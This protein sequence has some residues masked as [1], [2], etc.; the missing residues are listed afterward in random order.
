MQSSNNMRM[1]ELDATDRK[2]LRLLQA[3]GRISNADLAEAIHLSP[4]S[5]LRRVRR[6]ESSGVIDRYAMLVNPAAIGK[7][8]S[9][10]IEISLGSQSQKVL[11]AFEAAVADSSEVME[12]Y[13]MA[14]QS[15]YLLRVEVADMA[16]YERIHKSQLSRLPGVA[17]IRSNFAI[18]MV[19]KKSQYEL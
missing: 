18:R 17:G 4:S 12:C 19:C 16:D 11:D 9:I 1:I 14:G 6:L 3:D 7:P 10:F 2:I 5:C 13:L 15:D 8:T